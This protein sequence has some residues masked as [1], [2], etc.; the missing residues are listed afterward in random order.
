MK[1]VILVLLLVSGAAFA[2]GSADGSGSAAGSAAPE[3]P[4][5][6]ACV[7]AMNADPKF[8][9]SIVKSADKRIDQKTIDAHD[10][11]IKR[12]A[13]NDQHVLWAYA[14]LWVIAA[15]LVGYMFM[16][17]QKLK[18]EIEMLKQDLAKAEK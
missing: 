13:E 6:Q 17:Q 4:E 9:D 7:A 11:A 2:D 15:G 14:A 12:I 3:S 5:H 18:S 1:K 8:A 10:A 16:R